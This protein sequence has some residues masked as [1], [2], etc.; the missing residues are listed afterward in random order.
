GRL[1][2]KIDR[3]FVARPNLLAGMPGKGDAILHAHA[4]DGH[5][6]QNVDGPDARM[7]SRMAAEVDPFR[8]LGHSAER[9]LAYRLRLSG[10][11]DH[12]AVVVR[13]AMQIEHPCAFD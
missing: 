9:R 11:S 8:G 5:K 7:L 3:N 1:F 12:R 6:G 13:V 4:L 2:V 10:H